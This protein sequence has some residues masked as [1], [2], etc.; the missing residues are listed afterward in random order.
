M[1]IG[2]PKEIKDQETRVGLT[3]KWVGKLTKQGHS[4]YIQKG[5]ANLAGIADETY[6]AH[7]ARVLATKEE[8]YRK[9]ELIIKVKDYTPEERDTPFQ[10]QQIVMCYF[11]LGEAEPD[12]PLVDNLIRAKVT[13]VSLE[14]IQTDDA[15]RPLIKPMSDI[16]GRV[17]VPLPRIPFAGLL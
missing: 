13:A 12:Q 5:L 11:H 9:S 6:I 10:E 17:A 1:I 7:G 2:I 8:L 16:A 3:P 15:E 14:L 4:V